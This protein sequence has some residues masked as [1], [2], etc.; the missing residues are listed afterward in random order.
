MATEQMVL[1]EDDQNLIDPNFFAGEAPYA[2]WKRHRREAPVRWT[3]TPYGRGYWSLTSYDRVRDIYR[4]PVLFSSQRGGATL[5]LNGP[6]ADPEKSLSIRLSMK[7]AFLPTSDPPRHGVMRRALQ[8]HF[9]AK[10]VQTLEPFVEK[11]TTELIG[12]LL[13]RGECDF[14]TDIAARLPMSVIFEIMQVPKEDWPFLFRMANQASA[15]ADADYGKGTPLESRTE[16]VKAICAYVLDLAKHRRAN[17]GNDLI[18]V[19]ATATLDGVP[20]SDEEIGFNG[21]M[22]VN[23]GQETTRNSLT[24]GMAELIKEPAQMRRLRN[25]P[26]LLQTLPDEFVRWRSPVTHVLRTATAD[27]E[28]GGQKVR[29][30]DWLVAWIASANRDE[31]VFP[32]PDRFDIGRLPNLH[33]GFGASDH[34]CLGVLLARLQLRRIMAAFLERV[35]DI[36]LTGPIEHVAS[37]QFAGFKRMPVRVRPRTC[38]AA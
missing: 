15:P 24:A 2:L 28:F 22:F 13:D 33:L 7:G 25:E 31:T 32:D 36:E 26:V 4:N 38:V 35:E 1:S 27:V 29:E 11:L 6:M 37:H 9:L 18:S 14:V 20:F 10:A 21:H 3:Q 34:Y 5:P 16:A 8:Q 12:N 19:L 17:P 23:A 30:G